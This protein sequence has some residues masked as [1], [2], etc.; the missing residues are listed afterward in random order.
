MDLSLVK[1]VKETT[2]IE[3][4][5]RLVKEN[6]ILLM[7]VPNQKNVFCLGRIEN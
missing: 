5:N 1:E 3:L 4:V 6:W 2:D 7:I